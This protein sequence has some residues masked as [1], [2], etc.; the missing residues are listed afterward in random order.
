M[1]RLGTIPVGEQSFPLKDRSS[2]V[3]GTRVWKPRCSQVE[4]DIMHEED[5]SFTIHQWMW[6]F[7]IVTHIGNRVEDGRRALVCLLQLKLTACEGQGWV[8]PYNL[9]GKDIVYRMS[10][11]VERVPPILCGWV[12]VRAYIWLGKECHYEDQSLMLMHVGHWI[13]S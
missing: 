7:Q 12:S 11:E 6:K 4:K 10:L 9:P 13:H 2:I 1:G 8:L 3:E 5:P